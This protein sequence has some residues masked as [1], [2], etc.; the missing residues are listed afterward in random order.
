MRAFG[1]PA[2]RG[3]SIRILVRLVQGYVLGVVCLAAS[4]A[5]MAEADAPLT[6]SMGNDTRPFYYVNEEGAPAG[7]LVELWQLWSAKT[8]APVVFMPGTFAESLNFVRDGQA[9]AHIGCFYSEE[10]DVYLDYGA[11]VCDVTTHFFHDVS[12]TGLRT[13]SDL[14]GFVVG[15]IEGDHALD[16]LARNEPDLRLQIYRDNVTLFAAVE[17]RDVRVF[18]KDTAVGVEFLKKRGLLHRFEF[19]AGSPL[20]AEPFRIAVPAGRE[21]LLQ[22]LNAGMAEITEAERA[23]LEL[24]WTGSSRAGGADVLRVA[25]LTRM[26]PYSDFGPDGRPVGLFVDLAQCIA[27]IMKRRV[28]FYPGTLDEVTAGV[29]DGH[30]DVAM[31]VLPTP[32]LRETFLFSDP[33][34]GYPLFPFFSRSAGAARTLEDLMGKTVGV[35]RDSP[36]ARF[37]EEQHP[38]LEVQRYDERETMVLACAQGGL[39][40]LIGEGATI[41]ETLRQLGIP[42]AVRRGPAPLQEANGAV[43]VRTDH[44]E[45]LEA[46]NEAIRR[47]PPHTIREIEQRWVLDPALWAG[48]SS[49]AGAF[50]SETERQW[51]QDHPGIQIGVANAWPPID[52]VGLDGAPQGIGADILRLVIERTGLDITIVPGPVQENR[53]AVQDGRRDAIMDMAPEVDRAPDMNFTKPYA[54]IPLVL[55]GRADGPYFADESQINGKT[56][57]IEAGDL[58]A[59]YFREAYPNIAVKEYED[60]KSALRA[61]SRGEA[62]AYAGNRAVAAYVIVHEILNNLEIMGTLNRPGMFLA[63]GTRKDWPELRD[64]L[65]KALATI[66]PLE[67]QAILTKW[68]GD[69]VPSRRVGL[70][71]EELLFVQTAPPLVFSEVDW[72]PLSIVEDPEHYQ[73]IIADYLKVITE[74]S[75]LHFAFEP[76]AT[77]SDVLEAYTTGKIDV[78]PAIAS[79]DEVDREI[80]LTKPFVRFPLVIVARDDVSYISA[81]SELNGQR[82]AVGRGYTS[83]HFLSE[84]YPEIGLIQVDNVREGLLKV[85]EGEAHAFV[86]HLAVAVD[87]MQRLG[88]ANLKIAGQ[89]EFEFEHR[90]G[91]DPKYAQAVG[92]INK[93]LD[94]LSQQEHRA[95][96]NKWLDVEVAPKLDYTLIW[97]TVG[98]SLV[99]ILAIALWNRKLATLNNKLNSEIDERRKTQAALRVAQEEAVAANRAKSDFLA[100][101]SHEIR[102][103]MNAV[104]G[105]SHLA[106]RTALTPKQ[107]DYLLKIERSAKSLLGII[108][109]ILDFSKIEAGKLDVE[110]APFDLAEAIENFSNLMAI[111]TKDREDLEVLIDVAAEVP[112]QLEGDALRLGQVLTNLG[113]NAAKFTERG[114]IILQVGVRERKHNNVLLEFAVRDTG[115]GMTPEQVD[116]LFQAFSQADSSTTRRYGGTGLGLSISKRLVELMGG[117]I[118]VHSEHG[119]GSAFTFTVRMGIAHKL[120]ERT[121]A[122]SPVALQGLRC[123]V[124][125]DNASAREIFQGM[126]ESFGFMTA[127]CASGEEAVSEVAGSADDVRAPFDIVL[128]DWK[129]PG[130][131]GIE[132]VQRIRASAPSMASVPAILV[133][134]YGREEVVSAA[135]KAG[136]DQILLKPIGPSKLYDAIASALGKEGSPRVHRKDSEKTAAARSLAGARVLLVEDNEINQ[137]VASEMLASAGLL[138]DVAGNG[139]E[140]LDTIAAAVFD[141]VLMDVQMPVMDGLTATRQ[142]RQ[143]ERFAALPV[144]AMTANALAGDRERCLEGGMNDY[145]SKPI[146]PTQLFEVLARWISPREQAPGAAHPAPMEPE[147]AEA[148]LPASIPGVDMDSGL[149]R[150]SGNRALYQKLLRQFLKAQTGASALIRLALS[151]GD[152]ARA[153]HA[154]HTLK[155]VAGNLGATSIADIATN[156]EK[157]L[158]AGSASGVE[159]HLD[160][161][162]ERMA[163]LAEALA[164]LN[165]GREAAVEKA[166][167]ADF[168][169]EA[170][171]ARLREILDLLNV[172]LSEAVARME[173]AAPLLAASPAAEEFTRVRQKLELFDT[174]GARVNL[175]TA[176]QLLQQARD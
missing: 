43:A 155:G 93:V 65:D 3:R 11:P 102:T 34:S 109:D 80:L 57:A 7:W 122:A 161:L 17:Q 132:A 91:I 72:K 62:A 100:T 40:A 137:Q 86:G 49:G 85:S 78:V 77:W 171:C 131:S 9:D 128:M 176:L 152:M 92:I 118:G 54:Q 94:G 12:I 135:E 90:I 35:V 70:T 22:Q 63:F 52:F 39:A 82:V 47:I 150:V 104:I 97:R 6:I 126:L 61:V 25:L 89:T 130:I 107:E 124:V 116:R 158:M 112:R 165:T 37:M 154:A 145:V 73:G 20:Y 111:R 28:E 147:S 139:Q 75:G 114:E 162:D 23:T 46:V 1:A 76:S 123:L 105:L 10:R 115:I 60:A 2:E 173:E 121:A 148:P 96:V 68:I 88:F 36:A 141:A 69:G 125:D 44:T 103:P 14:K 21:A 169:V 71:Q 98:I 106:L 31:A 48:K 33:V 19:S 83:Y 45:L 119:Q 50:L 120:R 110:Q 53:K 41:G 32:T 160:T 84:N 51:V 4:T 146:D 29:M 143:E 27:D 163:K 133:T 134:A 5:V 81:T 167:A 87:H 64:I 113:S 16:F 24:K 170:A 67:H 144:I 56:V 129:L 95:I 74:R 149:R 117:E 99:I 175:E 101:M 58:P 13:L 127:L 38:E 157:Q 8:G 136:V 108:N 172:D 156:L 26:P 42:G 159:A 142:L 140:A 174:E 164:S 79:A 59:A 66:T 168:D 138:V 166:V 153:R 18:V 151:Q 15:V 30:A 55:V